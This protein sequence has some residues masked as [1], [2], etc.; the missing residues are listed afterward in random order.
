[1]NK[2]IDWCAD[3]NIDA[4]FEIYGN[5]VQYIIKTGLKNLQDYL[6]N[7]NII[8]KKDIKTLKYVYNICDNVLYEDDEFI[9]KLWA[10]LLLNSIDEKSNTKTK[11]IFIHILANLTPKSTLLLEQIILYQNENKEYQG[12]PLLKTDN[13]WILNTLG[14]TKEVMWNHSIR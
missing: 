3:I 10:N 14:L 1:M 11:N 9:K 8:P 2:I 7:E 5:P 4:L 12:L 13:R 6:K